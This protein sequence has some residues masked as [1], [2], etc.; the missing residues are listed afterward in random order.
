MITK[1]LN[2]RTVLEAATLL[3]AL[4][5]AACS[6]RSDV[7]APRPAANGAK[8]IRS[9]VI[10]DP[11]VTLLSVELSGGDLPQPLLYDLPMNGG[12]SAQSL[13]IPSGGG[14]TAIVRGYDGYGNLT[15]QGTLALERVAVGPNPGLDIAL[16]PV[17]DGDALRV[18][19]D[20][21]GEAPVDGSFRI[22]IRADR[23][24][25]Y[26]GQTVALRA[27][28]YNSLGQVVAVDPSEIHWAIGDPRTGLVLPNQTKEAAL[29]SYTGRYLWDM[30]YAILTAE[31][32]KIRA[33][34]KELLLADSWVD[35]SAGG[36]AT[37]AVRQSGR[38][39]CWGLNDFGMLG[40]SQD[41]ACTGYNNRCNSAPVLVQ[42][43]HVFSHVS[44]GQTHV[45]AL[46][47]YTSVPFCWGQNLNGEVGVATIGVFSSPLQVSGNPPAFMSISAGWEHTCGVT[48][49]FVA[50]CWGHN[51]FSQ[52]GT[53][54]ASSTSTPTAV[55]APFNSA[56]VSYASVTAGF[57]HS[58]GI[59]T[60]SRIFC[61][62]LLGGATSSIPVE[63][64]TPFS[65]GW[66]SLGQST[67]AQHVCA[68]T[69]TNVAWCWGDNT[70]GQLGDG[71]GGAGYK[72]SVPVGVMSGGASFVATST[73]Y[74]HS[75]ALATTSDAYCWGEDLN[76]ELGDGSQ[77]QK[78][79]PVQVLA[80]GIKFSKISVGDGHTCAID[81]AGNDIY[82]WGANDW[83]Q[84]GLGTRNTILDPKFGFNGVAYPTKVVAP[85]P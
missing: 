36:N 77:V 42:G 68:T 53:G 56:Q 24:S 25:I 31:W 82:C 23:R 32:K 33:D 73:G 54:A 43:G 78:K 60:T 55:A 75:C 72:S 39:Y 40:A 16:A 85:I 66:A 79:T 61:W 81:Y 74:L 64:T 58:C 67:T 4:T 1:W 8:P 59:T 48:A 57:S 45:C 19:M 38:L 49:A 7:A 34:L 13:S 21:V 14:Y 5:V 63:E 26:D 50:M 28:V 70:S 17:R 15:Y 62:G 69:S 9:V 71:N 51:Q 10:S 65:Q 6:D 84:L 47:Y 2:H 35:L 44:V 80:S 52:L 20:L 83:G 12:E 37:C 27:T 30:N 18:S 3:C 46:E 41:S 11:A 76:G 29:A 22:V